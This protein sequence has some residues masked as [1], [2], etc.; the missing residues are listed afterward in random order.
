MDVVIVNG[1]IVNDTSEVAL[2][3]SSVYEL[4]YLKKLLCS[5]N[6]NASM[7]PMSGAELCAFG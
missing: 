7:L 5:V 2:S 3:A 1:F 6:S 4:A